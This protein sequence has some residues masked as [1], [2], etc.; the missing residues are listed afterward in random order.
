MAEGIFWRRC[1][2]SVPKC[3]VGVPRPIHCDEW[4]NRKIS[5]SFILKN[6]EKIQRKVLEMISRFPASQRR[7]FLSF[8]EVF[9]ED[10]Q[11]LQDPGLKS[12]P[13]SEQP[14]N[15]ADKSITFNCNLVQIEFRSKSKNPKQMPNCFPKSRRE[16]NN[17]FPTWFQTTVDTRYSPYHLHSNR[18][19]LRKSFR[20]NLSRNFFGNP[21]PY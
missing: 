5:S 15:Q 21:S 11:V 8:R 18:Q 16:K 13:A 10:L 4:K 2:I 20:P 3:L 14:Q 9:Q 17:F 1:R 7:V 12:E 6:V 19:H